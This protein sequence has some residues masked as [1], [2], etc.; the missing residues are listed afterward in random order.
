MNEYRFL[1]FNKNISEYCTLCIKAYTRSEALSK[2]KYGF[3]AKDFYFIK[4]VETK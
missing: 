3:N 1:I 2:I 4:C